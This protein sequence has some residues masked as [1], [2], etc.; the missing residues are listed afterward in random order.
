MQQR[1]DS[2]VRAVGLVSTP[3]TKFY[4]S[5]SSA[6]K[7]LLDTIGASP[8]GDRTNTAS[9]QTACTATVK[10]WP[11]DKITSDVM[12][13]AAQRVKLESL[14]VAVAHA[15]DMI[16]AA[17]PSESAGTVPGRL[18]AV[19]KR[20]QVLLQAVKSI[21]PALGSFYDALS[22]EQKARFDAVGPQLFA[23]DR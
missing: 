22:D 16:G 20:L 6:Q 4:D 10:A 11:T 3:L 2:L 13:T 9:I 12:P 15:A 19:G 7:A 17:C 5:L 21:E 14:Q 8:S 1:L 23:A 18:A